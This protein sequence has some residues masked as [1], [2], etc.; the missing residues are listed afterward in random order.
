[1]RI[2]GTDSTRRGCFAAFTTDIGGGKGSIL[3]VRD[4]DGGV[5]ELPASADFSFPLLVTNVSINQD[6]RAHF[7]KCF[8]D[9]IYTYAFG[10]D[11]G[12]VSIDF[13]GFLVKGTVSGSGEVG[14]GGFSNIT[15][16]FLSAYKNAR[17]SASLKFATLSLAGSSQLK[18]LITNMRSATSNA[19]TNI[20]SFTMTLTTVEVQGPDAPPVVGAPDAGATDGTTP[21]GFGSDGPTAT[22][23]SAGFDTPGLGAGGSAGFGAD[24]GGFATSDTPGFGT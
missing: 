4:K 18:G 11:V 16:T 22:A 8:N 9:R 21:G 14:G 19:E 1:M 5:I 6:E 3:E 15:D 17:L 23:P 20:Q 13:L 10:A 7:L 2:F 12:L 24:G